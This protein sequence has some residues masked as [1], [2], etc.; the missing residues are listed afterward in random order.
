MAEPTDDQDFPQ[1]T[2]VPK[3]RT[4]ISIVWIIP[5]LAAAVAIGIAV[6]R[7]LTEGPTITIV[8]D[9]V[10]GIEA[11]KTLIKYNDVNIGQITSVELTPDYTKV[12]LTAK[13]VKS[14]EGLI[15][16]DARFWI[17][18]PRI[19][20]S[21][22]SG[23]GTLLSGNYIGFEPGKSTKAQRQ[24]IGVEAP[25]PVI[26]SAV[27]TRFTLRT[28]RLGSLG[29]GAPIYFQGLKAGEVIAYELEP[30]TKKVEIKI[31]LK[32]PYDSYVNSETRF[33]D[34]S[35]LN[36]SVDTEG[37]QV[38][39]ES[40]AALLEG[41]LAFEDP[42]F[43][44]AAK[45]VTDSTVFTLFR[46]RASA[47][48][49]P[50]VYAQRYVLYS[51]ESLRGLSVHAP[52]TVFGLPGG[53]VTAVGIDLDSET[54]TLRGRV[55]IATYPERLVAR[56]VKQQQGTG[57][58]IVQDPA[59]RHAFVQHLVDKLGMR[60]QLKTGN[61][62][63]GKLYVAFDFFPDAP[64]VNIDWSAERPEFPMVPSTLPNLEAKLT[65]ILDKLDKLP[66]AAIG[67][68][69]RDVLETFNKTLKDADK[70]LR[71]IDSGVTPEVKSALVEF[72]KTMVTIDSMVDPSSATRSDLD[73]L[74]E[75]AAG[76][77]RSLRVLADYL[78]QNPDALIKGKY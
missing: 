38:H 24:F 69:V 53:E 6:Q 31:F 23:I 19:S 47:M 71:H 59:E 51:D 13:V 5:I 32:R 18:Q 28:T 77:A 65:G 52:V 21:G 49:E 27:G 37:V 46:D 70:A 58:R 7:I 60:A 57:E 11:G 45:P 50:P 76:A 36:V 43:P 48:K 61:L 3:K 35:G 12:T 22:I 8:F 1:A 75:E 16:E 39:M 67:A 64:E 25:P 41:G 55:E 17:V 20:L 68:D 2:L 14:A 15:V 62:L 42:P 33:W 78:E 29:V 30:E 54:Q 56:F 40:L 74:L 44:T 63:T 26:T 9:A 66:Y 4:R 10:P 34:A 72:R 73:T